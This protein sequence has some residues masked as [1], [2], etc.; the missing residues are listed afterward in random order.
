MMSKLRILIV[1]DE[2]IIC[3]SLR[4]QMERLGFVVVGCAAT[5]NQAI[6]LA[7][8]HRPNVIFM[9]IRLGG[10][11]DGIAVAKTIRDTFQTV[12]IFMSAYE[13]PA[14]QQRALAVASNHLYFMIKPVEQSEIENLLRQ[15]ELHLS[16]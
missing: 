6:T 13:D 12:L 11:G 4:L 10:D 15:I 7:L 8:E 5:A 2:G 1:E 3:L 16:N 14:I 9:D